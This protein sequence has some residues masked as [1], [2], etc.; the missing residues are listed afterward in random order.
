VKP[1]R[2]ALI[3]CALAAILLI[4]YCFQGF[5]NRKAELN[6]LNWDFYMG[7]NTIA[8]FER[9][10][11]V[12][13]NYQI[14]KDN[15]DCLAKIT[16]APGSYD[17]IFPSDYMIQIMKVRGLL[18]KLERE[19][20]TLLGNIGDQY[21]GNYYDPQESYC[22]PYMFGTTGF[23]VNRNFVADKE[24]T[25]ALLAEPRFRGRI[26]VIDDLRFTL[27]SALLEL[28]YDP[29][30]T[31]SAELKE[32]VALLRRVRPNIRRFS[33]DSPKGPMASGDLWVAYAWS[34]DVLQAQRSNPAIEYIIPSAGSLRF[35]DGI[36]IP[37]GARN[38]D[39]AHHFINY[40]LR[41][42][43]S[44]AIT[45]DILYG[46]TNEKAISQI[47]QEVRE[48]H[49]SFPTDDEFA[50]CRRILDVGD[51]LKLYE[52]AWEEVKR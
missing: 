51:S 17:V 50:R 46:N 33:A 45:N 31:N 12:K 25:W 48:N 23:A 3:L 10:F 49:A 30:T 14:Y 4:T 27:G 18:E 26:S 47:R 42:D 44:A 6:V 8:E 29:N 5:T 24:V 20:I 9:E 36:C 35:Q 7:R 38:S 21:R 41:P 2:L 28:R 13:V 52:E 32:A 34:G 19:R 39:V 15:E 37:K 1:L 43:V 11:N 16:A 40:L 22:V